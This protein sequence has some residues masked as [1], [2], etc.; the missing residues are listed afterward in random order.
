[1]N[2]AGSSGPGGLPFDWALDFRNVIVE[3]G[4]SMRAGTRNPLHFQRGAYDSKRFGYDITGSETAHC[5]SLDDSLIEEDIPVEYLR[6]CRPDG[7][8]QTVV[9]IVGESGIKGTQRTTAYLN[10]GQWMMEV[11][12]GD[13]GPLVISEDH[14]CR[15]WKV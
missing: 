15:I 7:P 3:V 5:V 14:L 2:G 9:V 12:Q 8:G 11:E 6:P 10:D 13:A 1:M 4:P